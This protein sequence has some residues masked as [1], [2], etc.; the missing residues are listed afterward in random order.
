MSL[1]LPA[2]PVPHSMNDGGHERHDDNPQN[3]QREVLL[4]RLNSSKE[5]A[6][7]DEQ[8]HPHD[9]TENVIE[10][11]DRIRHVRNARDE[12]NDRAEH[13]EE[14]GEDD[15]FA[16]VLVIEA[17]GGSE[18]L[19]AENFPVLFEHP[20]AEQSAQ[21]V[22]A[23]IAEDRCDAEEHREENRVETSARGERTGSEEQRIAGEER[24]EDESRLAEDRGEEDDVGEESVL[25]DDGGQVDVQMQEEVNDVLDDGHCALLYGEDLKESKEYCSTVSSDVGV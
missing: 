18:I 13:R 6:A 3:D 1:L 17:F 23:R 22:I 2:Q 21:P 5:V 15:G 25:F 14:A 12:R 7:P 10:E 16:A 24:R 8:Q 4:D 20:P 11:E 19:Q 9:S